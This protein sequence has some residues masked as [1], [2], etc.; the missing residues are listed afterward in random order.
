MWK[1]M[2]WELSLSE[3]S[4]L[5]MFPLFLTSKSSWPFLNIN[6]SL[7][8]PHCFSCVTNCGWVSLGG[9]NLS[10][11]FFIELRGQCVLYAI[12]PTFPE[13]KLQYANHRAKHFTKGNSFRPHNFGNYILWHSHFI[14]WH[15]QD[16]HPNFPASKVISLPSIFGGSCSVLGCMLWLPWQCL[17]L[18]HLSRSAFCAAS[19]LLALSCCNTSPK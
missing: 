9:L 16:L 18:A 3:T 13:K 19:A 6:A 15:S 7:Q 10:L 8:G 17:I 2:W 4:G 1:A 12:L 5:I 11:Q 14:K